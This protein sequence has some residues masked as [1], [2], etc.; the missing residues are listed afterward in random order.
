MIAVHLT[1]IESRKNN[2]IWYQHR[3]I[4]KNPFYTNIYD[5]LL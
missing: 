1:E 2:L 3:L 4:Y 5:G